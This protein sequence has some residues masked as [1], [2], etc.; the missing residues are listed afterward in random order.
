MRRP[1]ALVL[2]LAIGVAAVAGTLA[3]TRTATLGARASDAQVAA[4]TARLDR[5]EA[6]LRRAAADRPPALPPLRT[7]TVQPSAAPR[8]V[9]VRP[10]PVPVVSHG[11]Q[12]EDDHGWDESEEHDDD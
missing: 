9:F 6:S 10:A 2:S 4:R 1:H 7:A 8:L 12:G 3:A 11:E 5:F